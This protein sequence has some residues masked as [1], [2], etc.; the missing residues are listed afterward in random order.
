MLLRALS[1]RVGFDSNTNWGKEMLYVIVVIIIIGIISVILEKIKEYLGKIILFI[2]AIAAV[3]LLAKGGIWLF[4]V[5]G[6]WATVLK[7]LK[8]VGL[9]VGGIIAF[10]FVASIII[11]IFA[12]IRKFF[13]KIKIQKILTDMMA[14][15]SNLP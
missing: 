12:G 4:H 11:N 1:M 13:A 7:I 14:Y 9:I 6:G 10:I 3:I 15:T 8:I 5:I 2:L